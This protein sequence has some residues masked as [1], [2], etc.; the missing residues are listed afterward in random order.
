[1]KTF[2]N[3]TYI[4]LLLAF[5]VI[6]GQEIQI[7]QVD[8]NST[9]DDFAPA[10][11]PNGRIMYL[12]SERDGYQ[13]NV[14][15]VQ[16]TSTGWTVPDEISG[17]VND[18]DQNGSV[19]VTPDG[20]FMVFAAYE[21]GVEGFGRTD[22]YSAEKID[23]KWRNV[24][25]LGPMINSGAWD[26]QPNLSYDGNTLYFVSD[27]PG[28]EGGADIYF[29][30][31]SRDGWGK[32]RSIGK[33]INTSSDEMSPYIGMDNKSFYFAS[34]KAGGMGGFDLYYTTIQR[35]TIGDLKNIGAPINTSSN[36]IFYC[37]ISNTEYAYF[38][39]DRGGGIG[40]YDI[41]MVVP[42]PFPTDEVIMVSGIVADDETKEPLGSDIVV[43]DLLTGKAVANFRS[44]D[45]TGDYY[46]VLQ[47]GNVYSITAYKSGY[48]FYSEE[49]KIAPTEKGHEKKKDIFLSPTK[50]RLLIF[51][52]F[53]K[54]D[55]KNESIPELE[56]VVEYLKDNEDYQI[57]FEG[58]TDDQGTDAYNDELSLKRAESVKKYVVDAGISPDRIDTKGMGKRHPLMQGTSDEARARNRRVEMILIE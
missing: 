7:K 19:A 20:Q 58:H 16:R 55:L 5:G 24:Q 31:K 8:I 13:Q 37:P 11:S 3:A 17:Y 53:D 44:D 21:H 2:I 26:S 41:Y 4:F 18:G 23:G 32:A 43:T 14:Y 22:L 10:L 38:S 49:F 33:K 6:N 50:T 27:R 28:G 12:T 15:V 57:R 56:R 46:V 45:E 30:V 25:N 34:N 29:S 39:S 47:K 42:N 52:D 51:F 9:G 40:M 48:L 35:N 36:E 1:M 54:F